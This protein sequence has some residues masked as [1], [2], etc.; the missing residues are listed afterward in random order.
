MK[1]KLGKN[2]YAFELYNGA[3]GAVALYQDDLRAL[4]TAKAAIKAGI[5]VLLKKANVT[6]REVETV[7]IAGSFGASLDA[8]SLKNI[9]L[10]DEGWAGKTLFAG[11]AALDGA[12]FVL[13]SDEKKAFAEKTALNAKYVPLSGSAHFEKEFIKNMNFH[14]V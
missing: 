5:S 6:S 1:I 11:D 14:T 3:S 4:Q 9:G 10:I 12:A 13:G 2:G 7:H 8:G